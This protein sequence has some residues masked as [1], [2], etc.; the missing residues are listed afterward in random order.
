MRIVERHGGVLVLE[1][2]PRAGT[3]VRVALPGDEAAL[4]RVA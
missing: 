4:R 1:S 2:T 3:T